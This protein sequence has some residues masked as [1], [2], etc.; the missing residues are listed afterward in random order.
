MEEKKLEKDDKGFYF[1]LILWGEVGGVGGRSW[2]K[3]GLAMKQK[4]GEV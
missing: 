1:C 4:F 3:L 2:V